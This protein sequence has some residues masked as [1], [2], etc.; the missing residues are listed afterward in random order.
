MAKSDETVTKTVEALTLELA[1]LELDNC[2]EAE[3]VRR[4]STRPES[5]AHPLVLYSAQCDEAK[6]EFISFL[7]QVLILC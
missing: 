7:D 5:A 6:E 1:V 2:C 4:L 3:A